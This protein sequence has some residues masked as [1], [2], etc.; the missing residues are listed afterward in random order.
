[1]ELLV[2]IKNCF[3]YDLNDIE[4]GVTSGLHYF[5]LSIFEAAENGVE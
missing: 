3:S 1:L 4:E 5:R 2:V